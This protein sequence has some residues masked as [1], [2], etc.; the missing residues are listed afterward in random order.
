MDAARSLGRELAITIALA[1]WQIQQFQLV[2]QPLLHP[3]G[4]RHM[5]TIAGSACCLQQQVCFIVRD[6]RQLL[7]SRTRALYCAIASRLQAT[8]AA[9]VRHPIVRQSAVVTRLGGQWQ[10]DQV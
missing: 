2:E 9:R 7:I 6:D 4:G 1:T 5:V 3:K 10:S 8:H